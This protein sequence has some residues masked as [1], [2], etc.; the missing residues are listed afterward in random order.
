MYEY[1]V[2]PKHIKGKGTSHVT[3][4]QRAVRIWRGR[5]W[6]VLLKPAQ[7][8]NSQVMVTCKTAWLL[9]QNVSLE[10]KHGKK[11][12]A[13]RILTIPDLSCEA[14][15][16][17]RLP[18][19]EGRRYLLEGPGEYLPVAT[20]LR[21]FTRNASGRTESCNLSRKDL[22]LDWP[23][24][25]SKAQHMEILRSLHLW[26]SRY[27]DLPKR[28]NKNNLNIQH[29]TAI[30]TWVSS[31]DHGIMQFQCV[32]HGPTLFRL[33]MASCPRMQLK[34]TEVYTAHI[35]GLTLS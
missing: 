17:C 34:I 23:K 12:R 33:V 4:E 6:N 9:L 26:V 5:C 8:V 30:A 21:T 14:K 31:W 16:L 1:N 7:S 19:L 25:T 15:E 3:A 18:L 32:A 2:E 13:T 20:I 11:Y 24:P 35:C 27:L 10:K 29:A 22:E 28:I